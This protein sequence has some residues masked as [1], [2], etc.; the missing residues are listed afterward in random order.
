[1]QSFKLSDFTLVKQLGKGG[2]GSAYLAV[3]NTTQQT[4]CLKFISL[5]CGSSRRSADE[6]NKTLS[7]LQDKHVIQYYGSFLEGDLFCIVMEYAPG[8]S[9]F[10]LIDV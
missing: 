5:N 9:L 10:D 7:Q 1:M 2:F 3:H 8:G 4:V 6:E